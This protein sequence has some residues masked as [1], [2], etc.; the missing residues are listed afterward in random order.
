M[1]R[2]SSD[3]LHRLILSMSRAEKRYFKLYTSRHVLGDHSNH[4]TLFDAVAKMKEY[5]ESALLKKFEGE[6]F[7]RRFPI[8]KRR[9]YDMILRSL[10][11]FHAESSLETKLRRSMHQVE[12]LFKKGLYKDASKILKSIRRQAMEYEMDTLLLDI[13]RWERKLTERTNYADR[14]SKH[15]NSAAQE[16]GTLLENI[17]KEGALW[18]LKSELFEILYRKGQVRSKELQKQLDE[19]IKRHEL[20]EIP[21][22]VHGKYLYYQTRGAHAF[23]VGDL[24]TC[25]VQLHDQL[26]LL[27]ANKELFAEEP[28]VALAVMSNLIHVTLSLGE[29]EKANTLLKRFQQLPKE[30]T[31]HAGEDLELRMFTTTA[32]LELAMTMRNAQFSEMIT[33]LPKIEEHINRFNER[34]GTVRKASLLYAIAYMHFAT[35]DMSN[36][37]KWINRLLSNVHIDK[38]EDIVCFAHL[39]NLLINLSQGRTRLLPY[40][41]RSCERFLKTRKRVYQFEELFLKMVKDLMKLKKGKDAEPLL[42]KFMNDCEILKQDPFEAPVFEY[43][44][45]EAWGSAFLSGSTIEQTLKRQR[46]KAA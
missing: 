26:E 28:H 24:P 7:T 23:A 27:V 20:K 46:L 14:K 36:A 16:M 35:G 5:D 6:A 21:N 33:K 9:L 25:Q 45:P 37:S 30:M 12:I 8:A 19:I 2:T 43:L 34:L 29:E 4:Q 32:S 15:I 1:I 22:T 41:L 31:L 42:N 38:S 11:A 3:H 39:L 18:E 44:H 17:R 10:N 40:T 13:K